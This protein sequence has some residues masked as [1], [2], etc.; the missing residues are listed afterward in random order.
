MGKILFDIIIALI[1]PIILFISM[2]RDMKKGKKLVDLTIV[3]AAFYF[4]LLGY[5]IAT[6]NRTTNE[7]LTYL[8]ILGVIYFITWWI[9]QA[10]LVGKNKNYANLEKNIK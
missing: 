10:I 1:A 7:M 9:V 8:T 3:I 5:E 4:G 6:E 2:K